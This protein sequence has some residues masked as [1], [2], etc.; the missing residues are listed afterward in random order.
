MYFPIISK[1]ETSI[2][3]ITELRAYVDDFIKNNI[4]SNFTAEVIE[5]NNNIFT[6]LFNKRAGAYYYNYFGIK[7]ETDPNILFIS[8]IKQYNGPYKNPKRKT[9]TKRKRK[10]FL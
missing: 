8:G 9:N 4:Q 7:P 10:T 6:L 3:N 2:S 1:K 5:E